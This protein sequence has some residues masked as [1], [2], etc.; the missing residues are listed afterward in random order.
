[1]TEQRKTIQNTREGVLVEAELNRRT[2]NLVQPQ[3]KRVPISERALVQRINRKLA[4]ENEV[5][6][7]TR[8]ASAIQN[9]GD[10]YILDLHKNLVLANDVDPIALGKELGVLADFERVEEGTA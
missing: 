10:Y 4:T 1:M 9:L 5:L 3:K 8:G 6:K 2:F 7:K